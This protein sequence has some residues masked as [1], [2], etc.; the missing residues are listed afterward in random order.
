MMPDAVFF[1]NLL[2]YFRPLAQQH[3]AAQ[4]KYSRIKKKLPLVEE[5]PL[6][7]GGLNHSEPHKRNMKTNVNSVKLCIGEFLY[8][9]ILEFDLCL[10]QRNLHLNSVMHGQRM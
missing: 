9:F 8:T 7:S 6:L 10:S 4:A 3:S 2:L 1:L 5:L